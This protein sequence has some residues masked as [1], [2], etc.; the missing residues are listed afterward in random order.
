MTAALL[1]ERTIRS[2]TFPNRIVISPMQQYM[3]GRDGLVRDWHFVHLTKMAVGGAGTVFTEALA[4]EPEGRVTYH[5]L[6]V[7]SDDHLEGLKRVAG[8]IG[9]NGAVPAAQLIHAGRKASVA[10]PYHGFEPLGEKD[11]KERGEAPWP[12]VAASAI[13][14]NPGWPTPR[15]MTKDDI[16]RSLDAFAAGAR[17]VR[18]AGFQ[19]I[20]MHGAHGYLIHSFLSPLSN[21]RD[22]EYGG[23]FEGRIR[24]ALE[25]ADAVRSEW[26]SDLPFFYRLS[27][28]DDAEGGWTL[29]DSVAL[30][31]ELKKHEVDV[32]D[33]S[34]GGLGRRTTPLIIPREPGYQVPFAARIRSGAEIATMA[35]GLIMEPQHANGIVD[36]GDADFIAIGREALNNPNWGLH[37]RVALDGIETYEPEWPKPYGWW[38]YRRAKA[39]EA[40]ARAKAS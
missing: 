38:L 34:S 22:D 1:N 15:A 30:S 20:D 2:V 23:D 39:L 5:D 32:I 11:E 31:R 36:S 40:A 13:E 37:A 35:V 3:A 14:A 12:V 33:C 26:P 28:I 17:R 16:K 25:A 9:D 7:W 19:V 4:T 24:F 10:P 21:E 27:C 8:A 18:R 29:D 6:G